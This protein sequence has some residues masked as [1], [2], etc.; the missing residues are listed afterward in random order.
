M[1]RYIP[2]K[3]VI[4]TGAICIRWQL[5]PFVASGEHE[6]QHLNLAIDSSC[7]SSSAHQKWPIRNSYS[8]ALVQSSDKSF[9]HI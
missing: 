3:R 5:T 2:L 8:N 7:I 6:F 9:L 4:K 1:T